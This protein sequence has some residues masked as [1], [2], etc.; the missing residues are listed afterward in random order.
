MIA[1]P[2]LTPVSLLHCCP[3]ANLCTT[4]FF[5][6]LCSLHRTFFLQGQH[7]QL[8]RV[9]NSNS[10]TTATTHGD[11][12]PLLLWFGFGSVPAPA[13]SL[14]HDPHACHRSSSCA[15]RVDALPVLSGVFWSLLRHVPSSSAPSAAHK[16]LRV[17]PTHP[18]KNKI[19]NTIK[20]QDQFERQR[21]VQGRS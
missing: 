10:N 20:D 19:N 6:D 11:A 9:S 15:E 8:H 5:T 17:C 3:S 18:E 21:R 16:L 2:L 12:T 13:Q 7:Q 4:Y 1:S 14:S